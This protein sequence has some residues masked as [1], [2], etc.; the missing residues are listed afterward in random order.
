MCFCISPSLHHFVPDSGLRV[1]IYWLSDFVTLSIA[2][3]VG[4]YTFVTLNCAGLFTPP[5]PTP[6]PLCITLEW[7][8]IETTA[9]VNVC[10]CI[11]PSLHHFVPDSG[12]RV[13]IYW[14]SDFVTL[15]IA[16]IV[17][18]YTFVTLNCAGLF[19]PPPQLPYRYV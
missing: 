6:I 11:S 10:F 7:P 15:S 13:A 3:I 4:S 5:P 18:S 14:L 1:A 19:T 8:H 2:R 17:G 9:R 16:R 12:L